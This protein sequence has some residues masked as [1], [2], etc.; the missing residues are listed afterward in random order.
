MPNNKKVLHEIFHLSLYKDLPYSKHLSKERVE[1]LQAYDTSDTFLNGFTVDTFH[2]DGLEAHII[3]AKGYIHIFNIQ[4]KILITILSGRPAQ[5]TSYFTELM[6][7]I[8]EKIREAIRIAAK[9][10][11]EEN[12]NNL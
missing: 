12:A 11:E 8:P 3:D 7:P 1:R 4:K 2:K 9:R 5:I 10:N 6:K